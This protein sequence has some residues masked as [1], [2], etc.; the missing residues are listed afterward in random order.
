M[1]TEILYVKYQPNPATL[2]RMTMHYVPCVGTVIWTTFLLWAEMS[3]VQLDSLICAEVIKTWSALTRFMLIVHPFDM[4]K[5]LKLFKKEI[6]IRHV[7]TSYNRIKSKKWTDWFGWRVLVS[8]ADM[9]VGSKSVLI[10]KKCA[11][12]IAHRFWTTSMCTNPLVYHS[13]GLQIWTS[14]GSYF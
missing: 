2:T 12:S 9:H 11:L 1:L 8:L 3:D 4:P 5:G 13:S 7:D 10:V 6:I 14:Y